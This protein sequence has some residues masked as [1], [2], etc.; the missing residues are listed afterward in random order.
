MIYTLGRDHEYRPIIIF[1]IAKIKENTEFFEKITNSCHYLFDYVKYNLL[2]PGKVEK[3][4]IIIDCRNVT[5]SDISKTNIKN[6]VRDMGR[7][8]PCRLEVM[9]IL[10]LPSFFKFI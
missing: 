9:F 10:Y 7:F 6:V 5:T 2:V 4:V 3:W 1:D 8:Y